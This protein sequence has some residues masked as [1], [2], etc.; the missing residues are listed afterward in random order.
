MLKL[1]WVESGG[2][3]NWEAQLVSKEF[4]VHQLF[5]DK[6]DFF[7]QILL[8]LKARINCELRQMNVSALLSWFQDE[9]DEV[10]K[11]NL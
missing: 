7:S 4:V 11:E 9:E 1:G 10:Q 2:C 8:L 3:G 6:A 5:W